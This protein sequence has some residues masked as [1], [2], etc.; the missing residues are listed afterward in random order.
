LLARP[1]IAN[2]L[3]PD[4]PKPV[5][6]Y[7]EFPFR[8][9]YE[10]DGER[11]VVEDTIICEFDGVGWNEGI[12]KYREWKSHLASDQKERAILITVDARV[13]IYCFVG[14]AEYYMNDEKYPEQRPLTPRVYDVKLNSWDMNIYFHSQ[15]EI[16]DYYGIKLVCWEFSEPIVNSFK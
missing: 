1:Y 10:V 7:G 15:E 6:R 5:V 8:L 4:P 9:E 11:F 14:S 2:V 3:S 12:G 13:K 16:F